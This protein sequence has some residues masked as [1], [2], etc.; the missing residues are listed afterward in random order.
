MDFP[1]KLIKQINTAQNITWEPY[2]FQI[3]CTVLEGKAGTVFEAS[4]ITKAQVVN[5]VGLIKA[6]DEAAVPFFSGTSIVKQKQALCFHISNPEN[7]VVTV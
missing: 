7:M 4:I 2:K 5:S 1:L 6:L 3:V